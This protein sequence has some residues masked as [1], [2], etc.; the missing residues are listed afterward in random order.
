MAAALDLG[1]EL[2]WLAES[3]SGGRAP[4]SQER[5]KPG[6]DRL[7]WALTAGF[8]LVAVVLA[9]THFN[10]TQSREAH[11][12]RFTIPP[13]Q[14]ERMFSTEWRVVQCFRPMGEV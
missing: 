14:M 5:L 6:W 12:V 10:N 9:F 7:A 4:T 13:P 11:V 2:K 1:L 8:A 3:G